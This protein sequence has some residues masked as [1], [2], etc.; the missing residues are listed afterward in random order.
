MPAICSSTSSAASM[1]WDAS[2]MPSLQGKIAVV[3]G[4]N[5]GIGFSISLELARKGANVVLACRSLERGHKAL[6]QIKETLKNEAATEGSAELMQLDLADL[7]SIRSFVAAF[8]SRHKRLDLLINNAGVVVMPFMETADGLEMQL[9]VNHCGHF[10]LT[11]QL[12]ECLLASD[13]ARIVNVS[14]AAHHSAK[15]RDTIEIPK[16]KYN[17]WSAYINSKLANMVF[18]MEL[19]RRLEK[20][21]LTHVRCLAAHP[22]STAT[23]SLG[24]AIA[25]SSWAWRWLWKFMYVL[26]IYQSAEQGALPILYAATAPDAENGQYYGPDGFQSLWGFPTLE[27]PSEAA[28]SADLGHKLWQW[29]EKVTDTVFPLSAR[30]GRVA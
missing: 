20:L 23:N 17:P 21:G 3:T 22:G 4:A 10:A 18:T 12:W 16:A 29:S 9:G 25:T 6:E 11:A 24:P 28:K 7:G 30:E 13:A 27:E 2:Q 19:A 5:S 8:R 15:M 14:S 26:P 1:A